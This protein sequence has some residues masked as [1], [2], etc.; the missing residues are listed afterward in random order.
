M[1]AD[2]ATNSATETTQIALETVPQEFG[3][4]RLRQAAPRNRG[5]QFAAS[6]WRLEGN[7]FVTN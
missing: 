3:T 4:A 2:F 7:E 6:V 1:L 5:W